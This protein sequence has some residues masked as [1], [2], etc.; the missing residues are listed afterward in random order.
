MFPGGTVASGWGNAQARMGHGTTDDRGGGPGPDG[1]SLRWRRCG[2]AARGR[3]PGRGAGPASGR[4]RGPVPAGQPPT[5]N[6]GLL[7]DGP[8]PGIFETLTRLTPAF[9]LTAGLATR[10]QAETPSRWRFELRPDVRFQDGTPLTSAAVVEALRNVAAGLADFEIENVARRQ[11]LPRGLTTESASADGEHVV[12]VD[13]A[14]ANLRL[15][16]QL[17]NPPWPS[18]RPAPGPV[19]VPR[20]PT[21]RRARGPSASSPTAQG[22]SCEWRP[23]PTTGPG[24]RS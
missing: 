11:S 22:S 7:V 13:L 20:P 18:P 17:A 21:P 19:P 6:L 14:E 4:G 2:P 1:G 10:W 9:G 15:A 8:Q 5:P 23:T 24:L 3:P 16:E 12:V